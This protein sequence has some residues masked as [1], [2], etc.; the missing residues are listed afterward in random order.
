MIDPDRV[1]T[2]VTKEVAHL[3][4]VDEPLLE[5]VQQRLKS[6]AAPLK[7]GP[8][9]AQSAF[10]RQP[11][12]TI[13]AAAPPD[14]GLAATTARSGGPTWRRAFWICPAANLC[15]QRWSRS[16]WRLLCESANATP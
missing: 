9:G 8:K 4:I 16:S 11:A 13:S 10:C 6:D 14:T 7:G 1:D 12:R 5:R 15:N 2:F 3:R